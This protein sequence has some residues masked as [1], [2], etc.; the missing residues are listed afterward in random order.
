MAADTMQLLES[1]SR[2]VNCNIWES[3]FE[4]DITFQSCWMEV[5]PAAQSNSFWLLLK[6]RLEIFGAAGA[7]ALKHFFS[8]S[9]DSF[10]LTSFITFYPRLLKHTYTTNLEST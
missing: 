6:D 1:S 2:S 9:I 10:P 3:Y 4:S 8:S 5:A 7:N